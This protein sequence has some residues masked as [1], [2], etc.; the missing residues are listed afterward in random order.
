MCPVNPT[1][2]TVLLMKITVNYIPN[3]LIG[4]F[5]VYK[6]KEL[7]CYLCTSVYFYSTGFIWSRNNLDT[8]L[9]SKSIHM[10]MGIKKFPFFLNICI[11]DIKMI[12]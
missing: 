4:L 1:Q 11:N 8:V 3:L 7:W 6:L 12:D 5:V 2:R 9:A 10:R